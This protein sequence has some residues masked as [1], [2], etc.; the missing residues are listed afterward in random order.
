MVSVDFKVLALSL[1]RKHIRAEGR[2]LRGS[3][4]FP[5]HSG[6]C[7]VVLSQRALV[8]TASMSLQQVRY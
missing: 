7:P 5:I 4:L 6:K 2:G 8:Q 1:V 3:L